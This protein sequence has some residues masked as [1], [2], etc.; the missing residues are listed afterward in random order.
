MVGGERRAPQTLAERGRGRGTILQ[1]EETAAPRRVGEVEEDGEVAGPSRSRGGNRRARSPPPRRTHR[2]QN[3]RINLKEWFSMPG[4]VVLEPE[5]MGFILLCITEM[6]ADLDG[7]ATKEI[8]RR[9]EVKVRCIQG[10]AFQN[11]ENLYGARGTATV[12]SQRFHLKAFTEPI[13]DSCREFLW[14]WSSLTERERE[15]KAFKIAKMVQRLAYM[16]DDSLY[17]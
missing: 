14:T 2:Q 11:I 10:Q 7:G 16:N 3:R 12:E 9:I 13:M 4:P 1:G 17:R 5:L 8:L 15:A 6:L